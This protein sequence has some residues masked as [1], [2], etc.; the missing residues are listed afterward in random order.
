MMGAACLALLLG[1]CVKDD[2]S[3]SVTNIRDAKTEQLKSVAALNNATAEATK[4]LAEADAALKLAQAKAAE[5]DAALTAARAKAAEIEAQLKEVELEAARAELEALKA[6]YAAEIAMYEAQKAQYLAQMEEAAVIAEKALIEAQEA[7]AKAERQYQQ[8]LDGFAAADAAM[9]QTLYSEYKDAVLTLIQAQKTLANDKIQLAQAETN[10]VNAEESLEALLASYDERIADYERQIAQAE[11]KIV[12]YE[13]YQTVSPAEAQA[14]YD[15]QNLVVLDLEKIRDEK[16]AER[17]AINTEKNKLGNPENNAFYSRVRNSALLPGMVQ[18]PIDAEGNVNWDLPG[19][20]WYGYYVEDDDPATLNTK[21]QKFIPLYTANIKYNKEH[22]S[23]YGSSSWWGGPQVVYATPAPYVEYKLTEDQ[24]LPS[25]WFYNEVISLGE[26]NE[27]A[28]AEYIKYYE[29]NFAET[30][31]YNLEE[32]QEE[33]DYW[34]EQR[35][36]WEVA[37]NEM[38]ALKVVNDAY[39]AAYAN[40]NSYN[41]YNDETGEWELT[42][43]GEAQKA[44]GAVN[45]AEANVANLKADKESKD[46]AKKSADEAL[47]AAK[48][49]QKTAD[50]ALV[51]ANKVV[52]DAGKDATQAQKDAAA[53]AKADAEAAATAVATATE[54]LE[55]ATEKA[56]WAAEDLKEAEAELK[57]AE[58][59][60]EAAEAELKKAVEAVEPARDALEIAQRACEK[61]LKEAGYT[62]NNWSDVDNLYDTCE[63]KYN[64]SASNAEQ[65]ASKVTYWTETAEKGAAEAVAQ[66][67]QTLA[68]VTTLKEAAADYIEEYNALQKEY[69][70][71]Y[72]AWAIANNDVNLAT[73]E[74]SAL[75]AILNDANSVKSNI[76]SQKN[77][78]KNL[79]SSIKNQEAYKVAAQNNIDSMEALVEE[80]TKKVELD[81]MWVELCQADAD[82][83]KAALEAATATPA[84]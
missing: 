74:R 84:E 31:K 79:E 75:N 24:V 63:N 47:K 43:Y 9:F 18:E 57:E 41:V 64:V 49:A 46:A 81:E 4:K 51:A 5:A 71:A 6:Q 58:A 50:E 28:V 13:K 33:Y 37:M 35:D 61:A 44:A 17:N 38:A 25:K 36:S 16:S 78:I 10:L 76:T 69:A 19:T 82:A 3:Q 53:A 14:A 73:A 1:S 23:N 21:E 56:A 11:A 66:M 67:E 52:A 68:E 32:A 48:E 30:V 54:A 77:T 8:T 29:A 62:V 40:A 83:K 22:N 15:E 72:V 20:F 42:A 27:E 70:E 34:V 2:E 65:W 7:L 60:A 12:I 59:A 39:Q 26:F 55:E 80:W 45:D